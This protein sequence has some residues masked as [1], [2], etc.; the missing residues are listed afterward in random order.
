[1]NWT[2][3]KI[4]VVLRCLLHSFCTTKTTH[5]SSRLWCVMRS[6]SS[7]TTGDVRHSGWMPE[8]LHSTSW[9]WN[10]TKKRLWWLFSG[11]RPVSSI[12]ASWIRVK[13][14]RQRS[15][16]DKLTKCTRSSNICARDW[17][18][19]RDQFSSMTMLACMLL[20]WPYRS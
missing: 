14:L 13:R 20:N 15:T 3:I 8:K 1:M 10:C 2:I 16:A 6:G 18:I 12:T 19:W 17:S 4:I 7:T 11:L 5:F 9:S